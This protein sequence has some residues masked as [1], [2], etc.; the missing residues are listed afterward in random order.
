MD[1]LEKIKIYAQML[2][3]VINEEEKRKYEEKKNAAAEKERQMLI[4]LSGISINA[5]PRADGRYQGYYTRDGKK[6]YVYGKSEQEVKIK[7]ELFLQNGEPKKK[8]SEK[9]K[10]T[11]TVAEWLEKWIELYKAPNLKPST[12]QNMRLSIQAAKEKIGE[13]KLPQ[14]TAENLQELLLSIEG[15]R[16]RELLRGY[17]D[18]AFKKAVMSGYIPRNPCDALELKK[19]KAERRNA[20]TIPQQEQF[21][22]AADGIKMQPL[23]LF[24]LSTGVRIGEALALTYADLDFEQQTVSVNKNV[25]FIGGKRID[26]NTPKSDA[27]V[28]IVPVPENALQLIRGNHSEKDLVFPYTYAGARSALR[29][30]SKNLGFE[31]TAH[32]L[33]HTYA[34]RLE[35]AGISPKLKQYLLGHA[36]LEMTQNTYTDVQ[37][38]YLLQNAERIKAAFDTELTPETR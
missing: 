28:R 30:V 3:E 27:G 2:L 21:L 32:L 31:V 6:H 36:S 34:T 18:Q 35:E 7:I 37:T 26:Q 4:D 17:L 5:K 10:A 22:K 15:L 20:L 12:L 14:V 33:R 11:P 23:L 24:L 8:Q 19:H 25:V 38:E 1:G 13:M 9:K 29:R 16:S